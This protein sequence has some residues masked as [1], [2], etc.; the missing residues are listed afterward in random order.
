MIS[1][2]G[3]SLSDMGTSR[4]RR[5]DVNTPPALAKAELAG[6]MTARKRVAMRVALA[7]EPIIEPLIERF[8]R[9]QQRGRG[10]DIPRR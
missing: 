3:C 5:V 10:R 7:P 8:T 2:E 1:V 4:G 6:G 9:N